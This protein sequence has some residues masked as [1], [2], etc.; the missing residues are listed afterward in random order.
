M[1]NTLNIERADFFLTI[2]IAAIINS[3]KTVKKE[4]MKISDAMILFYTMQKDN[5]VAY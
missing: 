4:S 5:L 1:P 2:F 3:T